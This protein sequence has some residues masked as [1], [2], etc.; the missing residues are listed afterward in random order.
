MEKWYYK[1]WFLIILLVG[2]IFI[3]PALLFVILISK[4]NGVMKN[5]NLIVGKENE[6]NLKMI[7]ETADLNLKV[8]ELEKEIKKIHEEVNSY[9][10][11]QVNKEL[12][13]LSIEKDEINLEVQMLREKS[14][15]EKFGLRD[16]SYVEECYENEK[17]KIYEIIEIEKKII[18]SEECFKINKDLFVDKSKQKGYLEQLENGMLMV[19]MFSVEVERL[20]DSATIKN[21][22]K[23]IPSITKKKKTIEKNFEHYF[24]TLQE[25]YFMLKINKAKYLNDSLE[26]QE[27]DKIKAIEEF[28]YIREQ[29]KLEK[30]EF[31]MKKQIDDEIKKINKQVDLYREK[32]SNATAEEQNKIQIEL[33]KLVLKN[34]ELLDEA[35]SLELRLRKIG[36]GYVYIISNIGSF[37]EGIY[38]IGFTK[39]QN[40]DDRIRELGDASVPFTFDKHA[41]IF[42][43]DA[44]QLEKELHNEFHKYRVNKENMRKEFFEVSFEKIKE[45]VLSKYNGTVQFIEEAPAIQYRE[46]LLMRKANDE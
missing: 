43:K 26:K 31:T 23:V 4:R 6:L 30:E 38:K 44:Y 9:N 7:E 39:R 11:D 8:V 18:M 35:E 22:D 2:S 40:P 24:L 1:R 13:S 16:A 37:G 41:M 42:S 25:D 46:S 17:N 36:A 5:S 27:Q 3:L 29:N 10:W 15:Y 20:L 32:M 21:I 12:E 33:D 34:E 45:T 19:R 14:K 28:N